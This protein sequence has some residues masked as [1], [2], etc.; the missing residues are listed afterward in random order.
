M[1]TGAWRAGWVGPL[2][3]TSMFR[4]TT[5]FT[6]TGLMTLLIAHETLIVV[7]EGEYLFASVVSV[8]G[9]DSLATFFG[10]IVSNRFK[11]TISDC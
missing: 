2:Y 1:P 9:L 5:L 10:L 4:N 11:L 6:S 8:Y 3:W 7:R